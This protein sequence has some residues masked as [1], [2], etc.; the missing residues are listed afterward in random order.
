[1]ELDFLTVISPHVLSAIQF[2]SLAVGTDCNLAR[3]GPPWI[4]VWSPCVYFDIH[5]RLSPQQRACARVHKHTPHTHNGRP[6][7]PQALLDKGFFT[8]KDGLVRQACAV[9]HTNQL[10]KTPIRNNFKYVFKRQGQ[11]REQESRFGRQASL[12]DLRQ[13][14]QPL[15]ASVC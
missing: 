13:V 11:H 1:M 9:L 5:L 7:S 6:L 12:C 15:C 8:P 4:A 3:S 2:W 10:W 14:T